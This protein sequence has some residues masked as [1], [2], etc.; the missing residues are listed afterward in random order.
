M[1]EEKRIFNLRW[2][3]DLDNVIRI[4]TRTFFPRMK[5]IMNKIRVNRVNQSSLALK[6]MRIFEIKPRKWKINVRV[7]RYSEI[8]PHE[9]HVL[10]RSARSRHARYTRCCVMPS[11]RFIQLGVS[12][13]RRSSEPWLS[14]AR[15]LSLSLSLSLSPSVSL[16]SFPLRTPSLPLFS[17][18]LCF[19]LND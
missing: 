16:H 9:H 15:A 11:R 18:F 5:D 1:R 8:V 3:R 4:Y 7:Y 17:P 6:E 13:V 14:L 2:I 19:F 12:F 10:T